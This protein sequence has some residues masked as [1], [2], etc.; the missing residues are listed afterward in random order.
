MKAM[1]LN[2]YFRYTLAVGLIL[3]FALTGFGQEPGQAAATPQ[4]SAF[5]SGSPAADSSKPPAVGQKEPTE[6]VPPPATGSVAVP[7]VASETQGSASSAVAPAG[8]SPA[9][10][11]GAG[12]GQEPTDLLQP[13]EVPPAPTKPKDHPGH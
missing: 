3:T 13:M 8:V 2:V 5:G 4:T 7:A 11:A 12:S 6:P 10:T 1:T 9:T